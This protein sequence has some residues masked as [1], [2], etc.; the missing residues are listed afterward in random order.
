MIFPI[1]AQPRSTIGWIVEGLRRRRAAGVPPF[2]VLSCDNLPDNGKVLHRALVAF[3]QATDADLGEVD[4]GRGG[5]SAHHGR[6]HHA[7]HRRRIAQAGAGSYGSGRRMADPA[8]AVYAVGGRGSA[9][10]ARR[11]LAIRRGHA[12][13]G[14]RRLRS[15]QAAHPQWLTF[16][17]RLPGDAARP[18]DRRRRHARRAAGPVHR[19][20]HDAGSRAQPG[21]FTRAG[22]RTL[23]LGGACPFP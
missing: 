17:A 15:R 23:R 16:H 4:R 8:R 12:G 11:G 10:D 19:A 7:G 22:H 1:A 20:A 14:C 18:R 21:R 9:G 2:A 13:E 6:Q 5:V 3:A